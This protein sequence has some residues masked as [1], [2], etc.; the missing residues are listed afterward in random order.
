MGVPANSRRS[1][2]KEVRDVRQGKI[3]IAWLAGGDL[4][5]EREK[6][7]VVSYGILIQS[8]CAPAN[9]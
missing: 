4:Y 9:L 8:P 6:L 7:E 2:I 3:K 5:E 1:G